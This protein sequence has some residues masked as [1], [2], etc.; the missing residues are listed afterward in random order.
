VRSV[1]CGG[2]RSLQAYPWITALALGCVTKAMSVSV[3]PA[4]DVKRSPTTHARRIGT[5]GF[6]LAKPADQSVVGTAPYSAAA[7]RRLGS[8]QFGRAK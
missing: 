8:T 7:A 3:T 6:A 4:T 2:P 5:L 1:R